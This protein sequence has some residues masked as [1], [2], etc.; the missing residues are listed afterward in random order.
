MRLPLEKPQPS[1]DTFV[2]TIRGEVVPSRPPLVELFLDY[3]IVKH[4]SELLLE[5]VWVEPG[6]SRESQAAFLRNWIEVY[7]RMGYD[8]LRMSGSLDFLTVSRKAEDKSL[9]SGTR[10]WTENTGPISTWED[11]ERYPWPDP[12]GCDLWPY[13]FVANNLPEGMG[14]FVCP[15]SGFLEIPL[16]HL[17][18]Y[19][20]LCLLLFDQPDLVEAVFKRVGE[21][22]YRFYE[23]TL[24]LPGLAGFFQGDDM[25][26][27][28]A[29]LIAP[30]ALRGL[31]LPWHQKLAQLAHDNGM[32]YLL[33]SC[34][35]L[36]QIM[37]DLITGV[38]ID[39]RHSFEDEGN[40]VIP[41]KQKYGTRIGVL[42]GVDLDKLCRLEETDLR[43][44]VRG[45]IDACLPGGRFA[46][47]SG[48]SVASY[49]PLKNYL[50]MVE[51]CLNY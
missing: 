4:V 3:D 49:V 14:L 11:F 19:E 39:A 22:I 23:R 33:H 38:R 27:K 16:D 36:E 47:G 2:R 24:G 48:N 13:E 41:F 50:V 1:I 30:D 31:S 10:S 34:G 28:T 18:G 29:T 15:T 26:F 40:P 42:G 5:R 20:S 45:I 17:I 7:H 21:I 12:D 37:E 35:N 6:D 32:L 46:L 43:K 44:Y 51:E 9:S 8:Y 25:G